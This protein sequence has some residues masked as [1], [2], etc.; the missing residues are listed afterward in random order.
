MKGK[1]AAAFIMAAMFGTTTVS[2]QEIEKTGNKRQ[3]MFKKLDTDGDGKISMGEAEKSPK[4]KIKENFAQIDTN[5]DSFLDK[6][7]LKAFMEIRR[8]KRVV[9]KKVE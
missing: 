1:I 6:D 5:K 9:K 8:E 7:E 3:E 4:G 2:A